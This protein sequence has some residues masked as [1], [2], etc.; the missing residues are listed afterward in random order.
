MWRCAEHAAIG[1]VIGAGIAAAALPVFAWR[2]AS[3][4]VTSAS[5]FLLSLGAFAGLVASLYRLPNLLDTAIEV[6]RQLGTP[7][8]FSSALSLLHRSAFTDAGFAQSVLVLAEAQMHD[9]TLA[10]LVA[11]RLGA[12]AWGGIG[13]AIAG[14]LT[15]AM[16]IGSPSPTRAAGDNQSGAAVALGSEGTTSPRREATAPTPRNSTGAAQGEL[17]SD[18]E[19]S[20]RTPGSDSSTSRSRLPSHITSDGAGPGRG[21]DDTRREQHDANPAVASDSPTHS[22]DDPQGSVAGGVGAASPNARSGDASPGVVRA[23]PRAPAP[24]WT[25]PTWTTDRAA[26]LRSLEAGAIPDR[27]RDLVRD[28]FSD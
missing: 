14:V 27:Y 1:A 18:R 21:G 28:Y 8:L 22:S 4:D 25:S 12:R 16:M 23:T 7:D 10:R 13:L 17:S 9:V 3:D 11:R 5:V 20:R 15:V 24:P 19:D 26:A 6:D 2:G